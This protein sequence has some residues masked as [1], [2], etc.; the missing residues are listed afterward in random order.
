[1]KPRFVADGALRLE[2][3][4]EF[5]ARLRALRDR[6]REKYAA[7]L[8]AAGLFQR[9]VL[10]WRMAVEYR[11]E[12]QRIVPSSQALYSSG[13]NWQAFS[14]NNSVAKNTRPHPCPP[15]QGEGETFAHPLVNDRARLSC[16]SE[17]KDEEAGTATAA[18]E[19]PSAVRTLPLSWG[20]GLG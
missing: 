17:A 3:S 15:P 9:C 7:E 12:R 19:F 11:R 2:R 4:E 6:I 18:S 8:S 14:R 20:R 5:Q 10:R 16:A 13:I 1:M